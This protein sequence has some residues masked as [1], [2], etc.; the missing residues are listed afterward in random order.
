MDAL[1]REGVTSFPT[2]PT[3]SRVAR[4]EFFRQNSDRFA[5]VWVVRQDALRFAL[6]ITTGTKPGVSDYLP[7]PYGLAGFAAPVEQVYPSLTPF[8]ELEDGRTIVATDGADMIEPSSDGQALR[9][10]WNRWAVVGSKPGAV[11]DVGLTSEVRWSIKN[12]TLVRAE[13]LTAKQPLT[14]RRWKLAVP[15]N[16]ANLETS[17]SNGMRVDRFTSNRSPE[18]SNPLRVLDE[19]SLEVRMIKSSFPV[20]TRVFATG[21]TPLGRGVR[22]A[23]PL[24]LVYE[25]S[26]LTLQPGNPIRYEIALAVNGNRR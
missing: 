3:L 12:N 15:T 5:G 26:N 8:L 21:D 9:V 24:H 25:A 19:G 20:V 4:F 14:V 10:L 23:I 16:H 17:S 2:V 1:D 13:T 11:V 18:A 6:P 22:G 7:V